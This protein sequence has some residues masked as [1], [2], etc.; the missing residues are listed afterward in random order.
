MLQPDPL[1]TQIAN[2][3]RSF[4]AGN[5]IS[6]NQIA[7][8]IGIEGSNFS[9]FVNGRSGLSAATVCRL[10]EL[11]NTSKRQLELRL[12]APHR[13]KFFTLNRRAHRCDLTPVRLCLLKIRQTIP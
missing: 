6:L 1:L 8:L 7:R 13:F 5:D 9:A 2:R 10:L 11:L 12:N 4:S 3:C